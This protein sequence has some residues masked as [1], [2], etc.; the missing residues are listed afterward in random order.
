MS[1]GKQLTVK[2]L[3]KNIQKVGSFAALGMA[4][5]VHSLAQVRAAQRLF[6]LR[7]GASGPQ[8]PCWQVLQVD[9]QMQPRSS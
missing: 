6:Y 1:S 2:Q 8:G 3:C 5:L 7:S 9:V 4:G